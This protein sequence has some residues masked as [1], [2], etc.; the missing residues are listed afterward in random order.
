MLSRNWRRWRTLP[1]LGFGDVGEVNHPGGFGLGRTSP[2]RS[3]PLRRPSHIP[4]L[5]Q[6]PTAKAGTSAQIQKPQIRAVEP[7]IAEPEQAAEHGRTDSLA[8]TS[9][10]SHPFLLDEGL[11]RF[12]VRRGSGRCGGARRVPSPAWR[13]SR[14][15]GESLPGDPF[16]VRMAGSDQSHS[17][18]TSKAGSR[19][20]RSVVW[21]T[22]M[23]ASN[24]TDGHCLYALKTFQ[25]RRAHPQKAEGHRLN[26]IHRAA[27]SGRRMLKAARILFRP[28]DAN[29][30]PAGSLHG[31]AGIGVATS[32]K[33]G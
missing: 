18:Y 29:A 23:C 2:V 17:K 11:N 32:A 31:F 30:Q 22:Q 24:V 27:I 21:V 28:N 9:Q 12:E 8:S 13:G 20:G 5:L 7:A 6:S 16:A 4:P 15:S 3:R 10:G 1:G 33:S 25:G 19:A 14:G 26:A